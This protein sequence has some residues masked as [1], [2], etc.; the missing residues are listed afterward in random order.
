MGLYGNVG[1][2]V[3]LVGDNGW[4]CTRPGGGLKTIQTTNLT[5][6]ANRNRNKQRVYVLVS[7]FH[8]NVVIDTFKM[9]LG[10]KSV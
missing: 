4:M 3:S 7:V 1:A 5:L 6:V 10:T 9:C 8:F 2:L